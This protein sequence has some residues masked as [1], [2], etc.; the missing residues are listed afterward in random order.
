MGFLQKIMNFLK[1][2]NVKKIEAPKEITKK[3]E[4]NIIEYKSI[5]KVSKSQEISDIL[6]ILGV[7]RETILKVLQK[8]NIDKE[9]MKK[10][11]KVFSDLGFSKLQISLIISSNIDIVTMSNTIIINAINDLKEYIK[12]K[13]DVF[14]I[15]YSN[16]FVISETLKEKIQHIKEIFEKIEIDE[17]TQRF[18]LVENTNI[19]SLEYERFEK[20]LMIIKE[21]YGENFIEKIKDNPLIIGIIEKNVLMSEF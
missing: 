7:D 12:D 17:K 6:R 14:D 16:P 18:I 9:N 20:S 10:N 15:V 8:Q 1:I 19:F 2:Q 13:E 4:N 11:L 5:E 21:F 3:E